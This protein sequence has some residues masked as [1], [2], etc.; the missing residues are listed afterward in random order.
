DGGLEYRDRA[1]PAARWSRFESSLLRQGSL[2]WGGVL[3][4]LLIAIGRAA[5]ADGGLKSCPLEAGLYG[6]A[7]ALLGVIWTARADGLRALGWTAAADRKLRL[8]SRSHSM[9]AA[10][11]LLIGFAVLALAVQLPAV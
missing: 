8:P 10:A 11:K 1:R 7:L 4:V 3:L 9:T 5:T 6:I 2:V